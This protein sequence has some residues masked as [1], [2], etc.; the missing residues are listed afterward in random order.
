M[1]TGKRYCTHHAKLVFNKEAIYIQSVWRARA[2]RRKMKNIFLRLDDDMQ[3]KIIWHMRE[4]YLIEKH[5]SSIIRTI[6]KNRVAD[7]FYVKKTPARNQGIPLYFDKSVPSLPNRNCKQ[8]YSEATNI[9][10]LYSKYASITDDD[11]C[12]M[13]YSIQRNLI[14][15][16]SNCICHNNLLNTGGG[17]VDVNESKLT[18]MN[19]YDSIEGWRRVYCKLHGYIRQVIF[20]VFPIS[21]Y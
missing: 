5:H 2:V 8:Y 16:C 4:Q 6:L 14:R 3:R 18:Y 1:L 7:L 15:S 21:A 19:L 10:N 11:Y 17:I 13:L 9:F 12:H 20:P